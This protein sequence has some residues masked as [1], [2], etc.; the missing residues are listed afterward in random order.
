MGAEGSGF[1]GGAV[2]LSL[3]P[4]PP[5]GRSNQS[6]FSPSKTTNS[7]TG[8]GAGATTTSFPGRY[9]GQ[10][11]P[12]RFGVPFSSLG[13]WSGLPQAQRTVGTPRSSMRTAVP[14]WSTAW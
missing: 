1:F 4:V 2:F 6:S 9:P 12:V 10:A 13:S 11:S 14:V 3:P 8:C 7:L 5:A